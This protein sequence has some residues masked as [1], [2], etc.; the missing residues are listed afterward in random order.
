MNGTTAKYVQRCRRCRR[1]VPIGMAVVYD[2]ATGLRHLSD[3]ACAA[4]LPDLDL[5]DIDRASAE[6]RAEIEVVGRLLQAAPWTAA[7]PQD[8]GLH[9]WTLRRQWANDAD[10]DRALRGIKQ[11]GVS[12]KWRTSYRRYFDFGPYFYWSMDP[13]SSP[14]E[15]EFLINRMRREPEPQVDLPW[16]VAR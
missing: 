10:F 11:L 8:W 1:W 7:K 9:D 16:E 6:V 3:D 2:P 4:A 5:P 12:R 13:T 15:I 14:V